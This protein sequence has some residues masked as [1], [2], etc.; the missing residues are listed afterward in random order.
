M[1]VRQTDHDPLRIELNRG[2][3]FEQTP[4]RCHAQELPAGFYV[5][6]VNNKSYK[7]AIK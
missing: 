6:V 5:V 1:T 2:D 7:I 4:E 3:M